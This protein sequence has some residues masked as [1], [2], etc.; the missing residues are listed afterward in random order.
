MCQ[1]I[2]CTDYARTNVSCASQ[3]RQPL[4]QMNGPAAHGPSGSPRRQELSAIGIAK[5]LASNPGL[6]PDE[7]TPGLYPTERDHFRAALRHLSGTT[8]VG[9]STVLW[10]T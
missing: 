10:R 9:P 3:P 4:I 2:V 5:A 8:T 7:P 6:L 1:L